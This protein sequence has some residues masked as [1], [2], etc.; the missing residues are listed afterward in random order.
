MEQFKIQKPIISKTL[1]NNYLVDYIAKT[2][3]DSEIMALI[4]KTENPNYLNYDEI[5]YKTNLFFPRYGKEAF[6]TLIKV[7]RD[8]NAKNTPIKSKDNNYFRYY[9]TETFQEILKSFETNI[10]LTTKEEKECYFELSL[11]E[12]AIFSSQIE[13]ANTS[14][15]LAKKM[16]LDKQKPTDS[17]Q[18]MI[19]NNYN[20]MQEIQGKYKNEDLSLEIIKELHITLTHN[21]KNIDEDK[22]GFFRTDA[23]QIV[24]GGD[25]DNQY[26]YEAPTLEF[27]VTEINNLINFANDKKDNLNPI[28]KA[29]ML[30]FWFAYLHPFVDGNGRLSRSLFYWFLSK[31]NLE[32][33]SF[34]PI[35]RAIKRSKNQ[36]FDAYIYTEQDDNDLN[37]FIDY[38][39]NKILQAKEMFEDYFQRK[40]K[41]KKSAL[42]KSTTKNKDLN[43]RQK[44]LLQNLN[45]NISFITLKDYTN[46]FGISKPTGIADLKELAGLN[47]LT[48]EKVGR[49]VRYS[50]NK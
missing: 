40:E 17:S 32:M 27:V 21:D 23:D 47:I 43:P 25:R 12:E 5:K 2:R 44:K 6:W 36:Y 37:Y 48:S 26:N 16:L 20:A 49:E 33:F 11:M 24:V 1:Y 4:S 39:L 50:I 7:H 35:S 13:G 3:D 10:N 42:K 31:N 41:E 28:I 34:Y 14:R 38:N 18:Q 29:I 15:K 46:D 30:H 22:K 19:V 8:T 9:E 45:K